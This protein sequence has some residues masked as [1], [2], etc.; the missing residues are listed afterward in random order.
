MENKVK[1]DMISDTT[2]QWPQ[3]ILDSP[4]DTPT[5]SLASLAFVLTQF[6]C[7]ILN[8][9]CSRAPIYHF[10]QL[11]VPFSVSP[12][13][14]AQRNHSESNPDS[15]FYFSFSSSHDMHSKSGYHQL[16]IVF[17]CQVYL[18]Y[19]LSY[20]IIANSKTIR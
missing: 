13:T 12:N 18:I 20:L 17:N 5:T 16:G 2:R 19:L 4:I 14:S 7:Q 10:L 15:P 9:K 8:K 11:T 6:L 3:I 1:G